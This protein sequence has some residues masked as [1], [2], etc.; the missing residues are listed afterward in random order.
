[1]INFENTSPFLPILHFDI[2]KGIKYVYDPE[3]KRS[4][5]YLEE[6]DILFIHK[7]CE[8]IEQVMNQNYLHFQRNKAELAEVEKNVQ[9]FKNLIQKSK[10]EFDRFDPN[11]IDVKIAILKQELKDRFEIHKKEMREMCNTD[12]LNNLFESHNELQQKIKKTIEEAE[13]C[14]AESDRILKES[15]KQDVK[16]KIHEVIYYLGVGLLLNF[17]GLVLCYS[18][19][20]AK[21]GGGMLLLCALKTINFTKYKIHP[22]EN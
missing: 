13:K 11:N 5:P 8:K 21:K 14:I 17:G 6:K 19:L 7:S 15:D 20:L 1:M 4:I 10:E 3:T 2:E 22:P 9:N 16:K 18:S 12:H